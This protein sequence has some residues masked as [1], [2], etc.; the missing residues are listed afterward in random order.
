M[1]DE[2]LLEAWRSGDRAAGNTLFSRYFSA[3]FRFFRNKADRGVEDLV[4]RTFM[5]CVEGRDRLR[6]DASFRSYLFGAAHHI[7][8]GH[9][10]RERALAREEDAD[11]LSIVDM[12]AS[13]SSL[14]AVRDEERLLLEGLRH[15]KLGDQTLLELY[16]W[17]RLSGGEIAAFLGV[18]EN[19]AR[20]RVRRAR[21]R[22][23]ETL[24]RLDA[25]SERLRSTIDNLDRWAASI[26][27]ALARP[28]T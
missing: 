28:A 13:P 25:A 11:E 9:Y 7:L 8:R 21:V 27:V 22:L 20:T 15:L 12:G 16:Y 10:R 5:A 6:A 24:A 23:E 17:E 14:L 3:V 1:T 2:E 19:T 4:Q 26:R 18:P